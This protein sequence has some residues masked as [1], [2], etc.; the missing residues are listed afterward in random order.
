[1]KPTTILYDLDGTLLPM[2]QEEFTTAYFDILSKKIAPRVYDQKQLIDGVWHSTKAMVKND[3]TQMNEQVFWKEFASLFGDK[4]NS[5]ID[6]FNEFYETD[7][8]NRNER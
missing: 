5:D 3:G 7:F 1:M 6:K 4:G 8:D 2:Q